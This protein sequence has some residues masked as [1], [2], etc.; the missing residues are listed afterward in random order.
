MKKNY[1]ILFL[2]LLVIPT[3]VFAQSRKKL[4][5]VSNIEVKILAM[6][7]LGNNALAKDLEPFYGFGFGGNL[8]TPINFGIGAD[9]SEFFSNRKDGRQS[10]Y[11]N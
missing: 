4:D 7:P 6:K 8:L 11:D 5:V 2:F 9:Y 10:I 3:I 1:K